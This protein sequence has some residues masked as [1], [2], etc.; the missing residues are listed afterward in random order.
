MKTVLITISLLALV[1][2]FAVPALH[3]M[4]HVSAVAS[5]TG[6]VLGTVGWFATAPFWIR[7]RPS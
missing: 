7:R 2:L 6:M 3:A 4:G 5:Q 1:V